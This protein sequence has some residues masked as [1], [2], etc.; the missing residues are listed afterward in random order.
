MPLSGSW[1]TLG[2]GDDNDIVLND[3]AISR[4]HLRIDWDGRRATVTDLGSSN[5]T[6]LGDQRLLPQTTREWG[7]QTLVGI[8]P[9]WLRLALPTGPPSV[10]P[11]AVS[12]PPP[13][14]VD[15]GRLRVVL[16]SDTL[17][18]TPGQPAVVRL[19]LGNLGSTVDHLRLTVEGVPAS[20][21]RVPPQEVQ[22]N[23]GTQAPVAL[24]VIVPRVVESY[25]GEYPVTVRARSRENPG[26]SGTAQ[27]LWSVLPFASDTLALAPSR[28]GGR[29]EAAYTATMQN[30]GNGGTRYTLRG[31]DKEGK[32]NYRF[33]QPVVELD[34]GGSADVG[35]T[36]SAP[37]RWIG[38]STV[39][40]FAVYADEVD[41]TASQ[42]VAGEFVH[43][44]LLPV[45]VP[46][47]A[48]ATLGLLAFLIVSLLGRNPKGLRVDVTPQDRIVGEQV[49]VNWEA[50]NTKQV[51]VKLDGTTVETSKDSKG[52]YSFVPDHD[53]PLRLE[54][55]ASNNA[56]SLPDSQTITVR[57]ADAGEPL[58]ELFDVCAVGTAAGA[59][60][61]DPLS[62]TLGD[63]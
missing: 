59:V 2:R 62:I 6:V 19:T 55:I 7:T 38:M 5:G 57:K 58:I 25:A 52:S 39:R 33:A 29:T 46:P 40:P 45:W 10:P 1:L 9:F 8:G 56:G 24:N 30:E 42:N 60:C 26:E 31:Q 36:V 16:E 35:L 32:L 48:L 15:A 28:A 21:V 3:G 54:V 20:W 17:T 13:A 23:P 61:P 41:G 34:P 63:R 11:P 12:A 44:A 50:S 53:G 51:A 47:L 4:H 49:T 18:L 14:E 27:A 22:L 37:R 43:G